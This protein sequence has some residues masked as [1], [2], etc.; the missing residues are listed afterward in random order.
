MIDAVDEFEMRLT[1]T[2]RADGIY[3]GTV[4]EIVSRAG[5][6]VRYHMSHGCIT[7]DDVRNIEIEY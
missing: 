3:L 6:F 5:A 7:E 1:N 2:L 4:V